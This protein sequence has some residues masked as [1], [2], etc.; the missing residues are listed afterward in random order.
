MMIDVI[1]LYTIMCIFTQSRW[2]LIS[3]FIVLYYY[4]IA[5]IEKTITGISAASWA[6]YKKEL[7]T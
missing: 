3:C 6:H 5:A 4:I 2:F 7:H 1:M